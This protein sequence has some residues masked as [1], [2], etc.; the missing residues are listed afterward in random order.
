MSR[1]G[2]KPVAIAKGAKVSVDGQTVNVEGP[3]GKLSYTAQPAI[4]VKVDGEE[5]VV[6]RRDEQ[7]QSKAFHG[8]TRALIANMIVGV[9]EGYKKELEVQGVGYSATLKGKKLELAVGF[10][11]KI[12]RDIPDGLNVSVDGNTKIEVTGIDKQQVGQFA[13]YVRAARKP[14]PYKGKGVRYLG[15][16]VKIKPGKTTGK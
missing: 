14:E 3:K 8:L 9:T 15:E 6:A 2:K 11:N 16:Q 7:R 5:V 1:L 10:A 12:T 13:A 4:E